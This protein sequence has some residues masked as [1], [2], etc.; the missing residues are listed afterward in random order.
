MKLSEISEEIT[1]KIEEENLKLNEIDTEVSPN[2]IESKI[3][4]TEVLKNKV[5]VGDAQ[6]VEIQG[7]K[8]AEQELE[9]AERIPQGPKNKIKHCRER[10]PCRPTEG[11]R[12]SVGES[13]CDDFKGVSV[14]KCEVDAIR[15]QTSEGGM[16]VFLYDAI[17]VRGVCVRGFGVDLLSARECDAIFSW[18]CG[19]DAIYSRECGVGAIYSRECGVVAIYLRECGVVAVYSRE[20]GVYAIRALESWGVG[21]VRARILRCRFYVCAGLPYLCNLCQGMRCL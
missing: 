4:S 19:V 13:Q 3:R 18:Q 5:S 10:E 2:E 9:V 7:V 21:A 14:E 16:N 17:H 6:N 20:C 11:N 8:L 12:N 15:Q 1:Q